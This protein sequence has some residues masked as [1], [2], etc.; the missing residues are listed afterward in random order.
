MR[1]DGLGKPR[2]VSNSA[3]GPWR[4][5][6]QGG[7]PKSVELARTREIGRRS[8]LGLE[9]ETERG[10]WTKQ[11]AFGQNVNV[12]LVSEN[13]LGSSWGKQGS[14]SSYTRHRMR[15]GRTPLKSRPGGACSHMDLQLL[16]RRRGRAS[17]RQFFGAA[18]AL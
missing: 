12:G 6:L 4:L 8:F 18:S 17:L 15:P 13:H 7:G 5:A 3:T 10:G 1:R 11:R 9:K 16:L 14:R 2:S